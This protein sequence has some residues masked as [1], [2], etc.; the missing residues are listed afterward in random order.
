ME[1][2]SKAHYSFII[3]ANLFSVDIYHSCAPTKAKLALSLLVYPKV[4]LIYFPIPCY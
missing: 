3:Y 1:I 4:L 2:T